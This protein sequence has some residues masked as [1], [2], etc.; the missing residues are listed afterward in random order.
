MTRRPLAPRAWAS[1][2]PTAT[3]SD[4]TGTSRRANRASARWFSPKVRVAHESGHREGDDE[5]NSEADPSVRGDRAA[6]PDGRSHTEGRDR[7]P[8][9]KLREVEMRCTRCGKE[10][11]WRE[12]MFVNER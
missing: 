5:G 12:G 4:S 10:A 9:G 1:T 11:W 6:E 2:D 3:P 8:E 7:Q